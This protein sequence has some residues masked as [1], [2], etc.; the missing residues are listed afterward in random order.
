MWRTWVLIPYAA[1]LHMHGLGLVEKYCL[2]WR[3]AR[4][5]V[6]QVSLSGKWVCQ[7]R[8]KL[9]ALF[10]PDRLTW[11]CDHIG[12]T[13]V[14]RPDP[15]GLSTFSQCIDFPPHRGFKLM[16]SGSWVIGALTKWLASRMLVWVLAGFS[17]R[18]NLNSMPLNSFILFPDTV[19]PVKLFIG[20][21]L[22]EFRYICFIYLWYINMPFRKL[23]SMK[24]TL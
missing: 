24:Y 21:S 23:L 2:L 6:R 19:D 9:W 17:T 1:V 12:V 20:N 8:A 7:W 3:Q 10:I 22:W 5:S 15:K 16:S 11:S 13:T 4:E 14:E 18:S